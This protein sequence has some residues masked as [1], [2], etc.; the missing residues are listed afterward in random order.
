MYK[1]GATDFVNWKIVRNNRSKEEAIRFNNSKHTQ[2]VP[3]ISHAKEETNKRQKSYRQSKKSK[4]TQAERM[5]AFNIIS[6][7]CQ[8]LVLYLL[9]LNKRIL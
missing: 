5:Y 9:I 7:K 6:L 8:E 2:S 1:A 3:N 4:M